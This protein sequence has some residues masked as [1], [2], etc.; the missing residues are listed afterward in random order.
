MT[1]SNLE[2]LTG[3]PETL[4]TAKSTAD[5]KTA[6]SNVVRQLAADQYKANNGGTD[7]EAYEARDYLVGERNTR[8]LSWKL[9]MLREIAAANFCEMVRTGV[10]G[11]GTK[12][13]G[14]PTNIDNTLAIYDAAVAAS[15]PIAATAYAELVDGRN[16]D[17]TE[18]TP[19]K[20]GWTN[21]FLTEFPSEIT[22]TITTQRDADAGGSTAYADMINQK[23]SDLKTYKSSLGLT[24]APKEPRDPNAP[25]PEKAPRAAKDPNAV[26][27]AKPVRA[28]KAAKVRTEPGSENETEST[29]ETSTET[30]GATAT[31]PVVESAT[32]ETENTGS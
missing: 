1:A 19:H 8:G 27:T 25:K 10:H 7:T 6:I 32:E 11:G 16:A 28:L 26:K 18:P 22:A 29:S 24:K 17:D 23:N 14:Q 9:N 21:K 15:E 3:L 13:I 31:E 4:K 20:V 30:E 12:I 5:V 2:A